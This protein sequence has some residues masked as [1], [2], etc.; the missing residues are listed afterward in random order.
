MK[1]ATALAFCSLLWATTAAAADG[2]DTPPPPP[3]ERFRLPPCAD[4]D[5]D[6]E[7]RTSTGCSG[8]FGV[9]SGFVDVSGVGAGTG[10]NVMVSAEGE[11]MVRR[12]LFNFH[13]S[14]RLAIGG[15]GAGFEGALGGGLGFGVRRPVGERHGP[16]ARGG[17]LGWMRGNDAYYGSLLELPEVQLGYQY[18]R[19]ITVV[20]IGATSGVV[21]IGRERV[22]DGSTRVLGN[23]LA[24]GGY[25]VVQVPWMRLGTRAMRLPTHDELRS[26]VDVVDGNLCGVLAPL[27][28]C[29]DARAARMDAFVPGSTAP[30]E[31]RSLAFGLTLGLTRER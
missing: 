8:V 23:G 10:T 29:A 17:V 30:T 22:G 6:G 25:L 13:G 7:L 31:V 3:A 1:L 19:G 20:E 2:P 21:L 27:A 11:E 18:M 14:H 9:R 24:V 28:L 15:G 4:P 16:V 26:E 12:G 5:S